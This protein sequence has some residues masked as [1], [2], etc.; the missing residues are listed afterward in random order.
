MITV[1]EAKLLERIINQHCE[2]RVYFNNFKDYILPQTDEDLRARLAARVVNKH[3]TSLQTVNCFPSWLPN[4]PT[5]SK[6][7]ILSRT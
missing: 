3:S 1:E 7:H 2:G 4:S 6:W 5:V